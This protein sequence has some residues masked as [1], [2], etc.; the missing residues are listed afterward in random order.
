MLESFTDNTYQPTIPEV[1]TTHAILLHTKA[2]F[3]DLSG[4]VAHV[5][6]ASLHA[7]KNEALQPGAMISKHSLVKLLMNGE[8]CS[9]G[10]DDWLEP[11]V[12]MDS[13][14][15]LMWYQPVKTR[16]IT[17]SNPSDKRSQQQTFY[18]KFPATLFIFERNN[19]Q[20]AMFGLDSDKRPTLDSMLYQLP[21]GNVNHRGSLCFGNTKDFIPDDPNGQN[22]HLIERCFFNALSTHTNTEFLF[23]KDKEENKRTLFTQVINYWRKKAQR[24]HRVNVK[25]DL[26]AIHTIRRQLRG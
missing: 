21:V 1:K 10:L 2:T 22:C 12:L 24:Q 5:A 23:R 3:Q 14:N 4:D 16:P 9:G 17:V 11:N 6:A 7:I 25:K 18:V 15:Y 8:N 20:L 19:Q 26:I 13:A